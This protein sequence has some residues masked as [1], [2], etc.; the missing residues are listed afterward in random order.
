MTNEEALQIY[1]ELVDLL[2]PEGASL[3]PLP[4][5]SGLTARSN[6][7]IGVDANVRLDDAKL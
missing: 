7:I 3:M 6:G 4:Q 1:V 2:P 5:F